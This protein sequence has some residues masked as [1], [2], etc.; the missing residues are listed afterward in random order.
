MIH[1]GLACLAWSTVVEF[2]G[3]GSFVL[4]L[5]RFFGGILRLMRKERVSDSKKEGQ[6][7]GDSSR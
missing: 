5:R 6:R 2:C 3:F 1:L 7:N 4:S